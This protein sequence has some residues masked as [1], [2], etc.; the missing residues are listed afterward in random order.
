MARKNRELRL[1]Q[2]TA[3]ISDYERETLTSDYRYRFLCDAKN[4]IDMGRSLTTRQRSWLDSLIDEG[5]P[6]IIRDNKTIIEIKSALAMRGLEHRSTVLSDFL[7]RV[8]I[9]K[10]L[11][12]KQQTF[13][14]GILEEAEKVRKDGPY[15]PEKD[16]ILKLEQCVYLSKA[17]SANYWVTHP[18]T[19]RALKSI[20]EWLQDPACFIDEWSVN[21]VIKAMS[22]R[23]RE[24][25][26]KPYA[27]SGDLVWYKG[28]LSNPKTGV[29][30]GPPEINDA[31]DIVYPILCDGQVSLVTKG[32]LSKRNPVR[33]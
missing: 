25:N 23:L 30:S 22:A 16:T 5:V 15:S 3:L 10:D 24:L 11:T 1:N 28:Q 2:T 8:S 9:G 7:A 20:R 12:P 6:E 26:D 17:Y 13:L 14:E 21:K 29:V 31:G 18:G 33:K 4:R 27:A 32:R 19:A